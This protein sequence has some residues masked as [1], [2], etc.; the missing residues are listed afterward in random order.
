MVAV[1]DLITPFKFGDDRFRDFGLAEGQ[2]LPSPYTLKVVLTTLAHVD[3][4]NIALQIEN[5][6]NMFF[7]TP[8]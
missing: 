3:A 6:K 7:K 1:H 5:M 2:T 4:K 8:I